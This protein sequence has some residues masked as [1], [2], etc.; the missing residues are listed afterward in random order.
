[1]ASARLNNSA[2]RSATPR[3]CLCSRS[4]RILAS[5]S[6]KSHDAPSDAAS[7]ANRRE[8]LIKPT[9]AALL[10]S[11]A[12]LATPQSAHALIKPT[13]LAVDDF[14]TG[15]AAAHLGPLGGA[16]G[17]NDYKEFEKVIYGFV[18]GIKTGECPP[19]AKDTVRAFLLKEEGGNRVMLTILIPSAELKNALPFFVESGPK[20][21]P[22]WSCAD[23]E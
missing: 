22:L 15:I 17:C 19:W 3:A 2:L 10:A 12:S 16:V 5:A 18:E 4:Q 9:A 21:N 1:M 7:V 14:S 20:A 6:P 13:A 8:F 23:E 11:A